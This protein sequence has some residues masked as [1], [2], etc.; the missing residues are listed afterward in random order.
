[1]AN[2]HTN[3]FLNAAGNPTAKLPR[4]NDHVTKASQFNFHALLFFIAAG[5]LVVGLIMN[6]SKIMDAVWLMK[7]E[8]AEPVT[9]PNFSVKLHNDGSEPISLP[10]QGNCL[11]WQLD[12]SW[13]YECGYEFKQT[14]NTDFDFDLIAVP[15]RGEREL[16]VHVTKITAIHQTKTSL[17]RFLTTGDWQVQFIM[18]TDQNGRNMINSNRIPFSVEAMSRSFVFEV[19]R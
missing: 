3:D 1:M 7:S 19:Y 11:L 9:I 10:T 12:Y 15:A 4:V 5:L 6:S 17:A 8:N 18:V 2:T 14:N 16:L 13:D